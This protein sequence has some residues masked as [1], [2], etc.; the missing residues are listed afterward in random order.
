MLDQVTAIDAGIQL[1]LAPV[2][3]ATVLM[4]ILA[5]IQVFVRLASAKMNDYLFFRYLTF[6]QYSEQ[7]YL[8]AGGLVDLG[9]F[10]ERTRSR[11]SCGLLF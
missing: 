7:Y 5:L 10:Q 6:Y 11:C 3:V 2:V 9:K 4:D 8:D 1:A